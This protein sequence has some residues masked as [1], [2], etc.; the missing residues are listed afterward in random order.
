MEKDKEALR[1]FMV[2]LYDWMIK[3]DDLGFVV[4]TTLIPGKLEFYI[5]VKKDDKSKTFN[6]GIFKILDGTSAIDYLDSIFSPIA[7]SGIV[8]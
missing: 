6:L 8:E 7:K 4:A 2:S 5:T 1:S 3:L